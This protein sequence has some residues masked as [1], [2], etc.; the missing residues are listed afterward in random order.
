M[1]MFLAFLCCQPLSLSKYCYFALTC[2][3]FSFASKRELS[4]M[5][6]FSTILF[7]FPLCLFRVI[8]FFVLRRNIAKQINKCA[9]PFEEKD[10]KV[11]ISVIYLSFISIVNPVI[12]SDSECVTS[13]EALKYVLF[14]VDVNQ[15]YDI[16]LGMYD[17]DLVLM[18]AEKSQKVRIEVHPYM[19]IK[20]L[21][22]VDDHKRGESFTFQWLCPSCF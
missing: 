18:V 15:M 22:L 11:K 2:E 13:E 17:F 19:D 20:L 9:Q 6:Y 21:I 4:L 5:T 1:L 3:E 12:T 8:L 14:L 7:T 10:V 16:A